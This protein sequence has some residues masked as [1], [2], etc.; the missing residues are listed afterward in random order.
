MASAMAKKKTEGEDAPTTPPVPTQPP[1]GVDPVHWAFWILGRCV[2]DRVQKA[3]SKTAAARAIAREALCSHDRV[4]KAHS[5]A[6][7]FPT[8]DLIPLGRV[9]IRGQPLSESYLRL[10]AM[11]ASRPQ[12]EELLVFIERQGPDGHPDSGGAQET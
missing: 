8:Q 5:F 12:A 7:M 3:G 10:L 4:L 1:P 11:V 2:Q 9:R 6:E